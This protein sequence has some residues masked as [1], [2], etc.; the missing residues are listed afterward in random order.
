MKAIKRIRGNTKRLSKSERR[1]EDIYNIIFDQGDIFISET[2][3]MTRKLRFTY[4]SARAKIETLSGAIASVLGESN[5]YIGLCSENSLEWIVL[6]FAI[7]RSGNKPYLVNLRQPTSFTESILKTLDAKCVICVGEKVDFGIEAYT[8]DGLFE[9]GKSISDVVMPPFANEFALSTSGTT[10]NEKICIYTG[11]E[12]AEQILN[13]ESICAV[14]AEIVRAWRS[15]IK[16][17]AFLPL[18][19]IFGFVAMF[20]WY[21]FFGATFV[22]LSDMVP[23]NILRTVRTCKVTHIF[24]VPLLWHAL[25]KA[26]VSKISAKDE[27]TKAKFERAKRLSLKLQASGSRLGKRLA[28][29]MFRDVRAQI[30]GESVQFCISGGSFIRPSALELMNALGYTLSN[31][32][33]MSEIGISSVE[34]SKKPSVRMLGSIG[35]PFKSVQYKIDENGVLLVKGESV[36]KKMII[37]GEECLNNGYFSTGDIVHTD[38]RGGYYIDGRESDIVFGDDGENLNP[39]FAERAFSLPYTKALCVLGNKDK[40]RLMLVVQ[41]SEGLVFEQ[42]EALKKKISECNASLPVSYQVKEIKFTYDDIMPE[43]AIKVSRAYL[44][45]M[46]DSGKVSLFDTLEASEHT[47]N[48]EES[49]L[50][51]VLRQMFSDALGLPTNEITDNGH[52]MNDLGG[53]SLDYFSLVSAINE[54]FSVTLDYEGDGFTYTLNDFEKKVKELIK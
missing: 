26:I 52:F 36:C 16:M 19:H 53:S 9:V 44:L 27:K 23:E 51:A 18:Y 49:A 45:K 6:F 14:N 50:K 31:G 22:F 46:L 38:K 13:V 34:L 35:K 42:Q 40:S 15:Q 5:R 3:T 1:F 7:L 2:A 8:Y 33:G 47:E 28:R 32:Y 37:N 48:G 4:A 12:M 10:L 25:E 29:R 11:Y 41:I 39:D 24:A 20:L 21:A 30:L 43:K 54:R 17:L